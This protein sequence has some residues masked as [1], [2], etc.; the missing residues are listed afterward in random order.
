MPT[1]FKSECTEKL[2]TLRPHA[3]FLTVH[4]YT[5][6]FG[7]IADFSI[8]FHVNYLK[9]VERAYAL[10]RNFKPGLEHTRKKD[11]TISDLMVA[12]AELLQSYSWTLSGDNPLATS[13]HAYTTVLNEDGEEIP[14]IKLHMDQDLLHLWGF[15]VHKRVLKSGTYPPDRRLALTKAKDALRQMSPLGRFRQF[16]LQP[17]RFKKL[18]VQCLTIKEEEV[19]RRAHNSL[20]QENNLG[21]E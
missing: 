2:A 18:V 3:T 21:E 17:G 14:G 20:S 9:S 1:T 12:R 5:N 6:N 7:E 10:V 16:R 15:G 11:F 8:V 4:H 13:A 19:V